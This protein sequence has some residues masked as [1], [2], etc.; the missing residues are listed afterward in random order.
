MWDGLCEHLVVCAPPNA[1]VRSEAVI[2][3]YL[4]LTPDA[5]KRAGRL[6]SETEFDLLRLR[7][8]QPKMLELG[9]ACVHL[10]WHC[11]GAI[12][13]LWGALAD[14]MN[15][16]RLDTM[17]GCASISRRDGGHVAASLWD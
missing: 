15:R 14:F 10:A 6:C 12:M 7:P 16:N 4:I 11:G 9:Q 13:A 1:E 2:G 5:A 17:T 8:P 3:T